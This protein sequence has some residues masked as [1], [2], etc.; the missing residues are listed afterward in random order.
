MTVWVSVIYNVLEY[1]YVLV[2][3]IVID[4][5][6]LVWSSLRTSLPVPSISE[7][8]QYVDDPTLVR[9]QILSEDLSLYHVYTNISTIKRALAS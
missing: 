4:N 7:Y 2:N 3:Q 5:L 6:D 8:P 1:K 9:F